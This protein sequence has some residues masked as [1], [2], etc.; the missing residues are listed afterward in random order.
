MAGQK[1][2]VVELVEGHREQGRTVSEVLGSLGVARSNYYRWKKTDQRE[3]SGRRRSVYEITEQ[4]RALIDEVKEQHPEYR[5]RRIQGALQQ[6][7]LYLSASVIYGH[8]KATG[9]VEPYERRPAPWNRPRYEVWQRNLLWGCDWTKL[10][11]GGV[12]W[13]LV[14]VI[15]FFSKPTSGFSHRGS[16][17]RK[18]LTWRTGF[19]SLKKNWTLSCFSTTKPLALR[20]HGVGTFDHHFAS[21]ASSSQ[22]LK[23]FATK[24]PTCAGR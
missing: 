7:G 14:T 8:L 2:G 18:R 1:Q 15:D 9:R 11:V 5:H 22:A 10:R 16:H 21:C 12:R 23:H 4:E 3:K 17:N 13:Y 6:R 19:V 20:S 24:S